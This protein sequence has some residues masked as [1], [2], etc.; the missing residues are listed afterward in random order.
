M[1]AVCQ[2]FGVLAV[3]VA[4][5]VCGFTLPAQ[6]EEMVNELSPFY[7]FKPIEMVKLSDRSANLVAGDLNKDGL[8]DLAIADNAHSRIDLLLQRAAKPANA[9]TGKPEVNQFADEI[10]QFGR[11]C[12]RVR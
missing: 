12:H 9:P 6:E 11:R 8:A 2:R 3:V 10:A 7:G 5:A 4:A 1:R